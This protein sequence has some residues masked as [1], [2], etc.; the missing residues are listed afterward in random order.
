MDTTPL[1]EFGR[2]LMT[3]VRDKAIDEW[4]AMIDGRMKGDTAK[5]VGKDLKSFSEEERAILKRLV[6][7]IVDTALHHLM[8]TLEQHDEVSL[9]MGTG[10]ELR[11]IS[12]GLTGD[13]ET[14]KER[15]SK[16]R[17]Y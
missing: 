7:E 15:Y 8:W 4:D 5:K 6:P 12:D 16:Q 9:R 2:L 13:L 10:P 11:S 1:D 14:W 3:K 17:V